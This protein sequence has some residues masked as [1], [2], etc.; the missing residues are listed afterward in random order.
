[1]FSII[2]YKS[3]LC[4]YLLSLL[5]H[6]ES[7]CN[8]CVSICLF[9]LFGAVCRSSVPELVV[10]VLPGGSGNPAVSGLVPRSRVLSPALCGG[11]HRPESQGRWPRW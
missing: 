8:M 6:K 3:E 2:D 10:F 7:M 9:P 11:T 1:M 5:Y 4:F